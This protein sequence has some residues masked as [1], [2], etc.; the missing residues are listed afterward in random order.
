MLLFFCLS[1][2]RRSSL[3][4][5]YTTVA[6][7]P[8]ARVSSLSLSCSEQVRPSRT[9]DRH[10]S[11]PLFDTVPCPLPT[12]LDCARPSSDLLK[13]GKPCQC[14]RT[15]RGAT[16]TTPSNHINPPPLLNQNPLLENTRTQ[17]LHQKPQ[18]NHRRRLPRQHISPS[19]PPTLPPPPKKKVSNLHICL[20]APPSPNTPRPPLSPPWISTLPAPLLPHRRPLVARRCFVLFAMLPPKQPNPQ[21]PLVRPAA[22]NQRPPPPAPPRWRACRR[23]CYCSRAR[24]PRGR[25]HGPSSS[26]PRPSW[27]R[28]TRW[29]RSPVGLFLWVKKRLVDPSLRGLYM[30]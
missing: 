8:H 22:Q 23:C 16:D 30:T 13:R 2:S 20:C 25:G 28:S 26:C 10:L 1:V 7:T 18:P 11:L 14:P 15:P 17:L 5:S 4:Q 3:G 21:P 29:R 27:W 9:C 6:V 19:T 24:A 12:R